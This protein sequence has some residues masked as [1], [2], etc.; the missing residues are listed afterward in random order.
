M[1]VWILIIAT[2]GFLPNSMDAQEDSIRLKRD[3]LKINIKGEFLSPDFVPYSVDFK[4][5][6]AQPF[7]LTPEISTI[8]VKL[9]RSLLT[10][11]YYT[12][13]SPMFYGD[14]STGGKILP[15]LYTSGF[16][17]TLPGIGRMNN[18][19][20]MLKYNLNSNIEFRGGVNVTTYNFSYNN[21]QAFSTSGV[22][23]YHLNDRLNI[24]VFGSYAPDNR[25]DLYKSSYGAIIG[26]DF[27]NRFGMG[28]G[29]QR[30]YDSMRRQWETVPIFVPYYKF[31]KFALGIDVGGIL[32]EILRNVIEDKR[33]SGS[34]VMI[35]PRR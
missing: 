32:Y 8:D 6:D 9:Q 24:S 18:A 33:R 7:S 11:P 35:P 3:S 19:T 29:V 26:Y 31:D 14:Y 21:G 34:P 25:Y 5:Q 30:N 4:K 10:P 22:L 28:M 20:L 23:T 15:Y 27:S 16:Q 1:K 17:E 13:P 12:N 2:L